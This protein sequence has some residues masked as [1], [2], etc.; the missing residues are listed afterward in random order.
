MVVLLMHIEFKISVTIN[1]AIKIFNCAINR[2]RKF[3]FSVQQLQHHHYVVYCWNVVTAFAVFCSTAMNC[4]M[5]STIQPS[6]WQAR[7]RIIVVDQWALKL[8]VERLPMEWN[9]QRDRWHRIWSSANEWV[10]VVMLLHSLVE[11]CRN[12][13]HLYFLLSL[14]HDFRAKPQLFS[15]RVVKKLLVKRAVTKLKMPVLSKVQC[16]HIP[17]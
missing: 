9:H 4:S 10:S 1:R 8:R 6:R 16:V 17:H 14:S 11:F 5:P 13:S 15:K 7:A 2:D 12:Q 3:A